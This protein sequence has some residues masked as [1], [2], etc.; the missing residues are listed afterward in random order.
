[1]I[2]QSR[3]A[4][5]GWTRSAKGGCGPGT[6]NSEAPAALVDLLSIDLLRVIQVRY[7]NVSPGAGPRAQSRAATAS[8]RRTGHWTLGPTPER[9]LSSKN[10]RAHTRA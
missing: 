7:L 5:C 9:V 8:T 1:M 2:Q 6:L 10:I 4:M 3:V